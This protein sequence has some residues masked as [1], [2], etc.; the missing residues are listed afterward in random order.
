MKVYKLLNLKFL[1]L[2]LFCCSVSHRSFS[3]SQTQTNEFWENIRF[4][5]GFGLSFGDGFFSGTLTP[6]AICQFND[7][8]GLGLRVSGT[9]NS[10]KNVYNSS[11]FGASIIS[12]FN[13]IDVLQLSSEFEYA[14]V[15]QNYSDPIFQDRTYWVPA[16]FV[17]LGYSTNNLVFG[18]RYDILYDRNKSIYADPI[19]PFVTFFF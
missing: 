18:M 2:F 13:P 6:G 4:T 5:G 15:N 19:S 1:I 7:N 17:G 9:Y 14:I 8:L 16:L 3:Q 11:I 10:L 12:I